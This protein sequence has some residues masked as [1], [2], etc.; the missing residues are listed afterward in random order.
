MRASPSTSSWIMP[1][2][3]ELP[4]SVMRP[5][6]WIGNSPAPGLETAIQAVDLVIAL[7]QQVLGRPWLLL[8]W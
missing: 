6:A 3:E 1:A 8:P 2:G 5:P 4:A 7:L